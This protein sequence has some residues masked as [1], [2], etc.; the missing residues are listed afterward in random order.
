MRNISHSLP[1]W[2]AYA[3]TSQ[4]RI[5]EKTS[6]GIPAPAHTPTNESNQKNMKSPHQKTNRAAKWRLGAI[7]ACAVV[8]CAL[9]TNSFAVSDA[10]A[11][12]AYNAFNSNFLNAAGNGYEASLGS[13]SYLYFWQQAEA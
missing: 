12:T 4:F 13:T 1:Q 7:A 2:S 3:E 11:T 6:L 9:P 10:D 5:T 8:A